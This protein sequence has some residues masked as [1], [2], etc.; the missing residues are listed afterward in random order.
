MR[1]RDYLSEMSSVAKPRAEGEWIEGRTLD[2]GG[3]GCGG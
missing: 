3:K 2:N 1:C